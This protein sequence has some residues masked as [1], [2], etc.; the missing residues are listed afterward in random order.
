[1]TAAADAT[2]AT[3]VAANA[4]TNTTANANISATSCTTIATAT[5]DHPVEDGVDCRFVHFDQGGNVNVRAGGSNTGCLHHILHCS[6]NDVS[7]CVC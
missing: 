5:A 3:S 1:M 7:L 2:T 6:Y 4:A